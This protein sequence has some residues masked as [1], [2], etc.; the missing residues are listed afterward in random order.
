MYVRWRRGSNGDEDYRRR[1]ELIVILL[2][3]NILTAAAVVADLT[4]GREHFSALVE[5]HPLA[6]QGVG[7]HPVRPETVQPR[8]RAV[9]VPVPAAVPVMVAV[10]DT[11]VTCSHTYTCAEV[12][13]AEKRG[14]MTLGLATCT[15]SHTS[16]L[17]GL[18]SSDRRASGA[19]PPQ[20]KTAKCP[21]HF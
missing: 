13:M 18:T 2:V 10:M 20:N 6:R 17:A 4:D 11:C 7:A 19:N 8:T 3:L 12:V 5:Q 9:P 1:R 21:C 15:F 14:G 16:L